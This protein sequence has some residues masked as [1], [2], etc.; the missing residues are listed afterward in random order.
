MPVPVAG[1]DQ[2]QM[3]NAATI[4]RV[5][6][7]RGLPERALVV[8]MATALQESNLYN[9]A[10]AGVPESLRYAHQGVGYDHDSIGLFQQRASQG[11][12]AVAQL[13]NPVYAAAAFYER[14]VQVPVWQSLSV[15]DAA[16]AVQRSAYPG[17][18][19]RHQSRAEQIVAALTGLP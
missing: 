10:N 19:Q 2:A 17:A 4:V 8:A 11:W 6:A 15:T 14:L 7:Q 13:M 12:G 5:G 3:N 16:Q 9:L 18:Y 1:L